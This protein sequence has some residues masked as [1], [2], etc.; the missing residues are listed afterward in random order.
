MRKTASQL[1]SLFV[2]TSLIGQLIPPV[3]HAQE[4]SQSDSGTPSIS[5]LLN[6]RSA[7]STSAPGNLFDQILASDNRKVSDGFKN[8]TKEIQND[9]ETM[10][11]RANEEIKKID[12]VEETIEINE[13]NEAI[14]KK[15][16][17]KISGTTNQN[18][19]FY[20]DALDTHYLAIRA[21]IENLATFN[22]LYEFLLIMAGED[23][24][25]DGTTKTNEDLRR[26]YGDK[27]KELNDSIETSD[28]YTPDNPPPT[29]A[30]LDAFPAFS[31]VNTTASY[32]CQLYSGPTP[33]H[34]QEP[35]PEAPQGGP[36]EEQ[37]PSRRQPA[38]VNPDR[39]KELPPEL[40]FSDPSEKDI[41][42]PKTYEDAK[43]LV[44]SGAGA[45]PR[46]YFYIYSMLR[47]M[48]AGQK[49]DG[50]EGEDFIQEA[51]TPNAIKTICG[52]DYEDDPQRCDGS[53]APCGVSQT[54]YALKWL[55]GQEDNMGTIFGDRTYMRIWIGSGS[56]EMSDEYDKNDETQTTARSPHW[57]KRAL[58]VSAIG[59]Y[60]ERL[61]CAACKGLEACTPDCLLQETPTAQCCPI[62][63]LPLDNAV[64]ALVPVE[65][66]WS[67]E[68]IKDDLLANAGDELLGNI[69]DPDITNNG[70][71]IKSLMGL[72]AK[73]A[74][75]QLIGG[76][77][78]NFDFFQILNGTFDDF[79]FQSGNSILQ[80]TI[81]GR[82]GFPED[83]LTNFNWNDPKSFFTTMASGYLGEALG[84]PGNMVTPLL[85][86]TM[87][88]DFKDAAL[89]ALNLTTNLNIPSNIRN[90]MNIAIQNAD[91]P[92]AI[93]LAFANIGMGQVSNIMGWPTG[94]LDI[95]NLSG[96]GFSAIANRLTTFGLSKVSG[97]PSD[98][99]VD[100]NN[101]KNTLSSLTGSLLSKSI[102][103][104]EI[105]NFI[106]QSITSGQTPT[107][108]SVLKQFSSDDIAHLLNLGQDK[109]DLANQI[110][111]YIQNPSS[112]P[113]HV[114]FLNNLTDQIDLAELGSQNPYF[115]ESAL[116]TIIEEGTSPQL[117]DANALSNI[118]TQILFSKTGIN[119]SRADMDKLPYLNQLY[120]IQNNSSTSF[121]S[122]TSFNP[123]LGGGPG[124]NNLDISN[125]EILNLNNQFIQKFGGS[126]NLTQFADR[127]TSTINSSENSQEIIRD[128][129]NYSAPI[130]V[131]FT[132]SPSL[133]DFLQHLKDPTNTD[134]FDY[135]DTVQLPTRGPNNST[136]YL[137]TN[138]ILKSVGIDLNQVEITPLEEETNSPANSPGLSNASSSAG[139]GVS[140]P[141]TGPTYMIYPK[142]NLA[143]MLIPGNSNSTNNEIGKFRL[144][145]SLTDV[146][147]YSYDRP[148]EIAIYPEGEAPSATNSFNQFDQATNSSFSV[149]VPGSIATNPNLTNSNDPLR[150]AMNNKY[151]LPYLNPLG[152][153]NEQPVDLLTN[154][155]S[156]PAIYDAISQIGVDNTK[157]ESLFTSIGQL[158]TASNLTGVNYLTALTSS[159]TGQ[160]S[161]EMLSSLGNTMGL[162]EE[163]RSGDPQQGINTALDFMQQY[164]IMEKIAPSSWDID[165]EGN[166]T[167]QIADVTSVYSNL[168]NG[169]YIDA[170]Q[171]I[172]VIKEKFGGFTTGLFS[173]LSNPNPHNI[174]L[175]AL[176]VASTRISSHYELDELQTFEELT[177][178]FGGIPPDVSQI[179]SRIPQLLQ[180]DFFKDNV[181]QDFDPQ[182]L[183]DATDI[184][185]LIQ[186]GGDPR[187]IIQNFGTT[188]LFKN[189][190]GNEKYAEF[191][192]A[193]GD[194][195]NTILSG[196]PKSIAQSFMNKYSNNINSWLSNQGLGSVMDLTS[197]Q[198]LINGDIKSFAKNTAVNYATQL[199]SSDTNFGQ[200]SN[201]VS[202]VFNGK[203][204]YRQIADIVISKFFSPSSDI[205]CGASTNGSM[206]DDSCDPHS[207]LSCSAQANKTP[208]SAK[209]KAEFEFHERWGSSTPPPGFEL[210]QPLITIKSIFKVIDDIKLSYLINNAHAIGLGFSAPGSLCGSDSLSLDS[211]KLQ[212]T[213]MLKNMLIQ[214]LTSLFSDAIFKQCRKQ[215]A[216]DNIVHFMDITLNYYSDPLTQ[217]FFAYQYSDQPPAE[218]ELIPID[219]LDSVRRYNY[220]Q[221]FSDF[222]DDIYKKIKDKS[223]KVFEGVW[224]KTRIDRINVFP[225]KC[226]ERDNQFLT[227]CEEFIHIS[228]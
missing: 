164:Q 169:N 157:A 175:F 89:S 1:V 25:V 202:S 36:G 102:G 31:A 159:F 4:N 12:T 203:V 208:V 207:V 170:L 224:Y 147:D 126:E 5:A 85:S 65:V 190:I 153:Y 162:L 53:Q 127:I 59:L 133:N 216:S 106:T 109:I 62:V 139:G 77:L 40:D 227:N 204:P 46:I 76:D 172:P 180:S 68:S 30:Q 131:K 132:N 54:T 63:P 58:D 48:E 35:S 212:M 64:D 92:K 151:S 60:N 72:M 9:H 205:L 99:V 75:N 187:Q 160:D 199:F 211:L 22:E 210:Y 140:I 219:E 107:L 189:M 121:S 181:F 122:N 128:L 158:Q 66:K 20:L 209:E 29:T 51:S 115:N 88:G 32:L 15:I 10:K 168:K 196:D 17:S 34:A 218:N 144:L 90:Y 165:G 161:S 7:S 74:F 118:A 214:K 143:D 96:Q 226:D 186:T 217:K 142:V 93:G 56:P 28:N 38:E 182:L 135:V 81:F 213:D 71:H 79:M 95:N 134:K 119:I 194:L 97:L 223:D 37:P 183:G 176:D 177:N 215:I 225:Q 206:S 108:N 228:W 13:L 138:N 124:L 221:I 45:D 145:E 184:F 43:Q 201:L 113:S 69:I 24:D 11:K 2:I 84:L 91:N 136:T 200:Y 163:M 61:D 156:T 27:T 111:E 185:S 141:A 86:A 130:L 87:S 100:I 8:W 117:G 18:E 80:G 19:L 173:T 188:Q 155:G 152:G 103:N 6:R 112:F 146:I 101:P 3:I 94:T 104:Y 110:H 83:F 123:I 222:T 14:I 33:A 193:N 191:L 50:Q 166:I 154:F 41:L 16:E 42:F 70:F 179:P 137:P 39:E 171:D 148:I 67:H 52:G 192:G 105:G 116:K 178:I 114:A 82:L 150:L 129:E 120:Q 78:K 26:E 197:I 220:L 49:E 23:A 73:N 44:N 125:P 47:Q 149:S 55:F 167:Q 21:K 195:V 198:G 57:D 174:Y 98:F